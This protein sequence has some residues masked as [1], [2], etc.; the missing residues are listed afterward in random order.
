MLG[1]AVDPA[2]AATVADLI[3]DR[4]LRKTDSGV[5]SEDKMVGSV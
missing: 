3:R 4:R 5:I 2:T 1:I